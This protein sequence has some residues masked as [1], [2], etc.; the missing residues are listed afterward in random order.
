MTKTTKM[1]AMAVSRARAPAELVDT[2]EYSGLRC[3]ITTSGARFWYRYRDFDTGK[4]KSVTIG[5]LGPDMT[6]ARAREVVID[7]KQQRANGQTPRL[8]RN[9]SGGHTVAQA[10][11]DYT[12]A[13][14][15]RRTPKGVA[16]AAALLKKLTDAHGAMDI[17]KLGVDAIRTLALD[18]TRKGNNRQA[19]VLLNEVAAVIDLATLNN[20]LPIDAGNPVDTVKRLLKAAKVSTSGQRRQRFLTDDELCLWLSWLPSGGF[21]Q[22]QRTALMISLWTGCRTGEAIGANWSDI[23][24]EVGTWGLPDTKT[25][26]PRVIRL[27]KQALSYL[28][29]VKELSSSAWVCPSSRSGGHLQQKGLTETMWHISKRGGE[30]PIAQWTPHDIRRTVRTG[31]SKLGCPREVAEAALGHTKNGVIGI[32]DLHKYESEV[33]IWLQ[34]WADHVDSLR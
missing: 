11:A 12:A 2:A 4:L 20:H 10:V 33:G 27:P 9:S 13:L 25:G 19:G 23:N 29:A 7:L 16:N 8:A 15:S 31:L 14:Q 6:L 34:Q 1:T 24:L 18:E 28:S 32:Y 26:I 30:A 17:A 5:H 3:S 22:G 21:S